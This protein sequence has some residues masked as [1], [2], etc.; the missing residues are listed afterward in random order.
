MKIERFR[1]FKT[2]QFY[3]SH[4]GEDSHH[5]SNEFSMVVRAGNHIFMRGQTGFDLEGNFH[6]END[7]IEQTENACR[8]IKQLLEEAGGR[9]EDV[10]KL[11]TYVTDRSFR[12]DVYSV[13]AKHFDGVYPVS[14]GLVVDGLALP[15]MLVEIDVEAV[16]TGEE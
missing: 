9:M 11:T 14:T 1:K 7:V 16:I 8:C 2:E 5:V 10:C 15:E 6:G 4:M 3:P 12:K 13:I